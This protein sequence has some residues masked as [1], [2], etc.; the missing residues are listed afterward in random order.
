[1]GDNDINVTDQ[2]KLTAEEEAQLAEMELDTGEDD[3]GAPPP[4]PKPAP[5]P[6]VK[7][8]AAKASPGPK[9]AEQAPADQDDGEGE[10]GEAGEGEGGTPKGKMVP[11]GAFHEERTRRQA[12][13]AELKAEREQ[14]AKD[15]AERLKLEERT[16]AILERAFPKPKDPEPEPIPDVNVD[17]VGW[18]TATMKA[19]G[20]TLE[21]IQGELAEA[22]KEKTQTAEQ[23]RQSDQVNAV[24][25]KAIASEREFIAT[26][27]DYNDA[28]A[29]LIQSRKDELSEFGYTPEQI[30]QVIAQERYGIAV[31]AQAA[32]KNPAA[33]VYNLAKKRGYLKKAAD[34]EGDGDAPPAKPA[35]RANGQERLKVLKEGTE[36]SRSL[37]SGRGEA[38]PVRDAAWLLSLPEA[39]FER[40][41]NTAEGRK[42]LGDDG[43]R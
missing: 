15:R 27:P 17:P 18:I 25:T 1:M 21:Q 10:G 34:G 19:T 16:N 31:Q 28:S 30:D 33:V 14:A 9:G 29:F 23:L 35:D 13:E 4:P 40:I 43:R 41:S 20:K 12:L 42:L 36:I 24:F 6:A 11:H 2:D 22:K 39:E 8:P 26:A 37:S 32:N 5:K 7:K 3:E 38:P